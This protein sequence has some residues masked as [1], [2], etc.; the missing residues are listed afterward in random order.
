[1]GYGRFNRL[2]LF[3]RWRQLFSILVRDFHSNASFVHRVGSSV[4]ILGLLKTGE[5]AGYSNFK[6][7]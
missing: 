7:G 3:L 4:L 5:V 2:V 6:L 1:M